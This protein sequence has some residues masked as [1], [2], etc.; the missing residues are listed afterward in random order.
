MVSR[1]HPTLKTNV[2]LL[3]KGLLIGAH[4]KEQEK[5]KPLD[6][7]ARSRKKELIRQKDK[8]QFETAYSSSILWQASSEG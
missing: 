6:L 7:K 3:I 2:L 8:A 5:R 1:S 4:Q